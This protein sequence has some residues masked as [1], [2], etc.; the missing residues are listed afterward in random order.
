MLVLNLLFGLIFTLLF[1]YSVSAYYDNIF[2]VTYHF[3]MFSVLLPHLLFLAED[4]LLITLK[5]SNKTPDIDV[6]DFGNL[7]EIGEISYAVMSNVGVLTSGK[8][9]VN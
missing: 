5:F 9:E 2:I 3:L 4:L 7:Q 1:K 6:R 8:L